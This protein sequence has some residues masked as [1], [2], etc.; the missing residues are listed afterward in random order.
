MYNQNNFDAGTLH[1]NTMTSTAEKCTWN[2]V[3]HSKT[4]FKQLKRKGKDAARYCLGTV[5]KCQQYNI[6]V[7]R[8]ESC[9]P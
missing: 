3:S 2:Y 4:T 6:S 8:N 7:N 1:Y 9:R 5:A